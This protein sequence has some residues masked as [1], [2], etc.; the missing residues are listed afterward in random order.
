[1]NE[2]WI[3]LHNR[4]T[5]DSGPGIFAKTV[6]FD[7]II[8]NNT[9]IIKDKKSPMIQL[10]TADCIGIEIDRNTLHGGNG[11]EVS[12][13]RPKTETARTVNIRMANEKRQTQIARA[14][15]RLSAFAQQSQPAAAKEQKCGRL[16]NCIDL[17]DGV[18]EV[19]VDEE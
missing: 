8:K 12:N 15:Y 7:H 11:K 1:M 16:G 4:F 14:A 6:S 3:I 18:V 13:R 17:E 9:F 19:G 5:V 2:N 10:A